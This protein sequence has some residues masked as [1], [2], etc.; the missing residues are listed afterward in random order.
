M[1]RALAAL[2]GTLIVILAWIYVGIPEGWRAQ[3]LAACLFKDASGVLQA[4]CKP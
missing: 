2:F 4:E 1:I 3:G